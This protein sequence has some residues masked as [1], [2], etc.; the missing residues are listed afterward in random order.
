MKVESVICFTMKGKHVVSVT[1]A[2][3]R[4]NEAQKIDGVNLLGER[5]KGKEGMEGV[6]WAQGDRWARLQSGQRAFRREIRFCLEMKQSKERA[7]AAQ[8]APHPLGS[9]WITSLTGSA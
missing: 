1:N 5:G 6:G 9:R 4:G 8:G 2:G 3:S 7:E